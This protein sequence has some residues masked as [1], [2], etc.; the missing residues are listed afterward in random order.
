MDTTLQV[1][2]NKVPVCRL[3]HLADDGSNEQTRVSQGN[4]AGLSFFWGCMALLAVKVKIVAEPL[5]CN[6]QI[7][8]FERPSVL[9]DQATCI[10]RLDTYRVKEQEGACRTKPEAPPR[11]S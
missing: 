8:E 2:Y 1:T 3:C 4:P 6:M 11:R 5:A 9:E 10:P 7:A